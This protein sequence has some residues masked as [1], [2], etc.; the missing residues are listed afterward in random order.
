MERYFFFV[1]FVFFV[2]VTRAGNFWYFL[3][4][5]VCLFVI[6]T[7]AGEVVFCVVYL[8]HFVRLFV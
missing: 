8:V 4:H 5:F 6:L 3:L 1:H 7:R 2:V